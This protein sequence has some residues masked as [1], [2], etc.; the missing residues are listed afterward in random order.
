[1]T[2]KSQLG[3]PKDPQDPESPIVRP[4][5]RR[6]KQSANANSPPG[7]EK[8]AAMT[9]ELRHL[10]GSCPPQERSCV[11]K[12]SNSLKGP[13]PEGEIETEAQEQHA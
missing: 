2:E 7:K 10:K 3:G 4:T 11:E 12:G 1:L 5:W 13:R 8:I 9:Q 6:M